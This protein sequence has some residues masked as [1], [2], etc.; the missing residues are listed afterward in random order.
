MEGDIS[1]QVMKGSCPQQDNSYD[2]GVY[3][4]LFAYQIG[5]FIND[6][7]DSISEVLA[8]NAALISNQLHK[9]VTPRVV[10]QYR[11]ECIRDIRAL[12]AKNSS[13]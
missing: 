2:C 7:R 9:S 11:D 5:Q 10:T 4:I 6:R 1:V 13:M 12:A 8:D 3:T